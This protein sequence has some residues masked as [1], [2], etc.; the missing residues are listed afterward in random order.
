MKRI[1]QRAT[2][3]IWILSGA[4]LT[5]LIVMLIATPGATHPAGADEGAAHTRPN[6]ALAP[7]DPGLPPAVQPPGR[8][9]PITSTSNVMRGD[10]LRTADDGF[11][12]VTSV[13]TGSGDDAFVS[14]GESITYTIMITNTGSPITDVLILDNLPG[15]TFTEGSIGCSGGDR[16]GLMV[17]AEQIQDPRSPTGTVTMLVTRAITWEV[18]SLGPDDPKQMVFSGTVSCQ[19][20]GAII[21]N[22]AF[23]SYRQGGAYRSGGAEETQTKVRMR[24]NKDGEA[25]LSEGPTW[26]SDDRGGALDMA[27]GDVD[28]DGDLDLAVGNYGYPNKV[29]LNVG[30]RLQATGWQSTDA[31]RTFSVALGDVDG[32]GDLDLVA[33]NAGQ[34]N[35][36]YLNNGTADPFAGVAGSDISTDAHWTYSV[37]LGDV[38]GDGDLDLV[39]GNAGQRNRLYLNNGTADPF[40]GVAGSDISTDAHWTYSVALGDVDSDGDLD[41]VAGNYLLEPNRLYLN[42]GTAD[43]FAGVAGSDI[44]TDAHW[45]FSVA[46]GDVDGD[47]DLDLVAGN[48]WGPNR[49]YLNNGTAD[50]FASVAGSNIST[51]AHWTFSVALGDVDGDGD[52]DLVAGNYYIAPNRLYLNNGTADPFASVVGS[53]IGTAGHSIY[54]VALGDV[55]GDGDLDLAVGDYTE[56]S[57]LFTTFA[58]LLN[59]TLA[60]IDPSPYAGVAWGDADHDG[61][62]DLLFGA[63][64]LPSGSPAFGS[65]LYRNE[66]GEFSKDSKDVIAGFAPRC[67]AFGDVDGD[68]KMDVAL[69]TSGQNEVYLAGNTVWPDWASEDSL[70]S[71]SVAWGDA[72]DDGDLD[73]LVGNGGTHPNALYINQGTQLD[74]EPTWISGETD[75][76]RS[77]AWGDFNR[78]RYLDFAVGNDGQPNRVYCNNRDNTFSLVWSSPYSSS[79]RSV[80]WGDYDRDG[81]LDLAVGN[82]GAESGDGEANYIYENLTC[83]NLACQKLPFQDLSCQ[84]SATTLRTTPVWTMTTNSGTALYSKTTSLAW[85]DWDNDGDLDLAVGNDGEPDQVYANLGS[86]PGKPQLAWLWASD[87]AARTTGVAWGD[88]DGDGD[89][90]LAVSRNG[91][92]Q[93]GVY[94]NFYVSPSHLENDF[95]T[96]MPLPNNPTYLSI[97]RPGRTDAAYFYSS[98]ELLS[99]PVNPTVTVRFTLFDPDGSRRQADFNQYGDDVLA[100]STRYEF[101]LDGRNDWQTATGRLESGVYQNGMATRRL[102]RTYTFLWNAQQDQAISDDARFRIRVVDH[103][104]PVN[105]SQPSRRAGLTQHAAISAIS[106]PFR[107]RGLSCQWPG[108]LSI[109]FDK[110][111]PA[112]GEAVRMEGTAALG[113]GVLTFTWDFG[114][115][116]TATGQVVRHAYSENGTYTVT[117]T[118]SGEKCPITEPAVKTGIIVVGTGTMDKRVYLPLILKS[119][120]GGAAMNAMMVRPA[121]VTGLSGSSQPGDGVTHLAWK[122]NGASGAIT[123]YRIYRRLRTEEGAFQLL[124]T[125]PASLTTYTDETAACGYAYYVTALNPVGES[126]PSTASYFSLPCKR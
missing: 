36:L 35:R 106:P 113:S 55:D 88:K 70:P 40:A 42:K 51:D 105:S 114:D 56:P 22:G 8:G 63:A 34:R 1:C 2:V 41:L 21:T 74:R 102:G 3:R 107:V 46:L 108:G 111:H 64:V 104:G 48:D 84:S 14:N 20:D 115:T 122:P 94:E 87:E 65:G 24:I 67:V 125:V 62:L 75:D 91:A 96:T 76:T 83:Q 25:T 68:G 31:H 99:G 90:D 118:V 17:E 66:T 28:G 6:T 110:P 10:D 60:G 117:L 58:P 50:P 19:A 98:A 32:D 44:S 124:A 81:D 71:Y 103:I 78:D 59:P 86:E 82:Y 92:G 116:V 73:L 18:D 26:C 85:G 29:F 121:Q 126:P 72:D 33:G 109:Q 95:A 11:E 100:S 123:G 39:V 37:A 53:D 12:I 54:S 23:Y 77:V 9:E 5:V 57:L 15:R 69:G 80:A 13:D 47:G 38:D 97:P 93:N 27:W 89:L 16:C 52:L 120:P 45:T 4:A 79:T 43:P 101:L 7:G 119:S 49:L 61:D 30:G 112:V